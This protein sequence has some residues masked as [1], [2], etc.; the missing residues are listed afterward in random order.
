MER[1]RFG[2]LCKIQLGELHRLAVWH[3]R[4]WNLTCLTWRCKRRWIQRLKGRPMDV[5]FEDRPESLIISPIRPVPAYTVYPKK[6]RHGFLCCGTLT[7]ALR[8][9]VTVGVWSVSRIPECRGKNSAIWS[10]SSWS[11]L[12]YT[13]IFTQTLLGEYQLYR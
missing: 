8:N 2:F 7:M 10:D 4:F 13:Q 12:M 1:C 9:R 3:G 6:G 11:H 5:L